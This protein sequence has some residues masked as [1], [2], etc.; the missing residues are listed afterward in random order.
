MDNR[1]LSLSSI[2]PGSMPRL[3]LALVLCTFSGTHAFGAVPI[4]QPSVQS[5]LIGKTWRLVGVMSM[6]DTESI[7]DDRSRYTLRLQADG[8]VQIRADCNRAMGN[9]SSAAAGKLRFGP[10]AATKAMCPPDSLHDTYLAQF[11]WVR[12]YV[13]KDGNLFL[14]TMADGSIVEFEPAPLPVAATV[15]GD[16]IHTDDAREVQE[17]I[18]GTLF[19]RYA[20]QHGI[21]VTDAELDAYLDKL[22]R[23]MRAHGLTAA[24]DLSP[25]ETVQAERMQRDMGRAM[26]LR[27]KINR[28]LYRQYGGRIIFQQLG[29]EPID[30][31]R[32][33]FEER[34]AAGDF[35]IHEAAFET[36]FWDYVTNDTRHSFYEPGSTEESQA[37]SVPPWTDRDADEAQHQGSPA[38]EARGGVPAPPDS[39]GPLHWEV[40]GV[41]TG[42]RLRASPSVSAATLTSY[43][44]GTLL[45]NLGCRLAEGRVWCDVQQLGGGPRGYVAAEFLTPA[46]SPNGAAIMGPDDSALR[47][48]QG[49]F[50]AS[51]SVPCAQHPD[52]AMRECPFGVSRTGGGYATVAVTRPDGRKRAI[53]FQMGIPIG[54]DTSEADG[55]HDFRSDRVNDVHYISVGPERYEIVDAIVL[56]G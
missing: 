15:L 6:N 18:I 48:G 56:G 28:S 23:G 27:W 9:W 51:G 40:T 30:A 38:G 17:V 25:E 47:A 55:Y 11:P 21:S 36:A 54:A 45:A 31:Y 14:A 4:E 37:F 34:H 42:L 44:G 3:A 50:D 1:N 20:E 39:G 26:I 8:S 16:D 2:S 22:R 13:M 5:A 35:A 46:V 52:Q 43:P 49:D 33:Y 32:A 7:P 10:L 19:D 41:A 29:P 24:D 53:F 12:S